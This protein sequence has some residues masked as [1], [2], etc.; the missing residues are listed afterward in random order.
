M[1]C[2]HLLSCYKVESF[3]RWL[4]LNWI[5]LLIIDDFFKYLMGLL[6][7]LK[8]L[9]YACFIY[10]Y[11]N[12][13]TILTRIWKLTSNK[14]SLLQET[15]LK[16][17][18]VIIY[19]HLENWIVT[20]FCWKIRPVQLSCLLSCCCCDSPAALLLSLV[21][22]V[23]EVC[24]RRRVVPQGLHCKL[25]RMALTV[26]QMLYGVWCHSTLR[27]DIWW[28][29]PCNCSK[30]DSDQ[31]TTGWDWYGLTE[32]ADFQEVRYRVVKL[33]GL[34]LVQNSFLLLLSCSHCCEMV[35]IMSVSAVCMY[36]C[37]WLL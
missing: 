28:L 8:V 1:I 7:R 35:W 27:T 21:V 2:Y 32:A 3:Y 4:N 11:C 29:G 18:W 6:I 5:K 16:I 19:L 34:C 13:I 37:E 31:N 25:R 23:E 17:K 9:I 30:A 12:T 26:E 14:F 10:Y 15:K 22:Q 24:D 33:Q 20:F 36:A